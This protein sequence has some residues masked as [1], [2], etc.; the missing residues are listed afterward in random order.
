MDCGVD[1]RDLGSTTGA[2]QKAIDSLGKLPA[3]TKIVIRGQ[4]QAMSQSFMTMGLG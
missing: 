3:G 4:S 1:G 2:V